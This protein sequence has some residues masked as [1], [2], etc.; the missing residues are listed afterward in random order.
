MER[1]TER[2]GQKTNLIRCN[3]EECDMIRDFL[4]E[5]GVE[6]RP[7]IFDIKECIIQARNTYR[8][9]CL[10]YGNNSGKEIAEKTE[11]DISNGY[12]RE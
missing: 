2:F 10:I 4:I 1:I 8:D 5:I 3:Y 9:N 7:V 6:I 11:K 12:W